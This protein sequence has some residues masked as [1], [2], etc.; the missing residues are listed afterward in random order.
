MSLNL[1][2]LSRAVWFS[3][4]L[5]Q[6]AAIAL[7]LFGL[8]LVFL[9]AELALPTHGLLGVLALL[10]VLGGVGACFVMNAWLGL[11]VLIGLVVATPFV[12]AFVMKIWPKTP[13]G[14]RLVLSETSGKV[15]PIAIHIGQ[16]GI[17]VSEL[18]PWGECEFDGV[19][20]ESTSEHGVIGSAKQVKVVAL[21]DGR[22]VVRE[23][24]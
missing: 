20:I 11:G 15:A 9:V 5:S 16:T 6:A 3:S 8:G 18:R 7:L 13:I 17:S 2:M 1:L 10:C 14:R 19:R 22:P 23:L 12:G 21:M 24:T 4:P